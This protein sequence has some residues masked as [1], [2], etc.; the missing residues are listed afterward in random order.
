[1]LIAHGV[2]WLVWHPIGLAGWEWSLPGLCAAGSVLFCLPAPCD[3][4][5]V[6]GTYFLATVPE[7]RSL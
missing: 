2:P 3:G 5:D 7:Y 4:F 6:G 1:M